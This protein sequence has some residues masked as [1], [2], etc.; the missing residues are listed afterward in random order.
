M[1]VK[2]QPSHPFLKSYWQSHCGFGNAWTFI[3]AFKSYVSRKLWYSN[4]AEIELAIQKRIVGTKSGANPLRYFDGATMVSYQVPHKAI[5]TVFCR[6]EP[7]P[8]G[9]HDYEF[10]LNPE[11]PNVPTS[12][13]E[14]K[15]SKQGDKSGR[16]VYTKVDVANG[17]YIAAETFPHSLRFFPSTYALIFHLLT[18]QEELF[19][20][21]EVVDYYVSGY[22][23]NSRKFVS[24]LWTRLF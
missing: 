22:G 9:C 14:V 13:M 7:A 1:S 16:G 4:A 3:V 18:K 23:F 15:I 2:F 20:D 5:E 21:L 11:I 17:T 10:S 19:E 6:R 8:L 12:S 24:I